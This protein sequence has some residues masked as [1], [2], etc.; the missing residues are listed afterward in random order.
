MITLTKE[1]YTSYDKVGATKTDIENLRELL[2]YIKNGYDMTVTG[3][4]SSN[5]SQMFKGTDVNLEGLDGEHTILFVNIP[6]IQIRKRIFKTTD[7]KKYKATPVARTSFLDES[8]PI[9]KLVEVE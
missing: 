4:R 9:V 5:I 1:N 7:G 8:Y 2:E 3:Y 6:L